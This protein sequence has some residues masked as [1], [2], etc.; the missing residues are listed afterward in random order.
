MKKD[1]LSKALVVLSVFAVLVTTGCG[2]AATTGNSASTK[3]TSAGTSAKTVDTC[4]TLE[5]FNKLLP[6]TWPGDYTEDED[7]TCDNE[8][9]NGC[10]ESVGVSM[11]SADQEN[12]IGLWLWAPDKNGQSGWNL[13][14]A[15]VKDAAEGDTVL[16]K[17][18]YQ[19]RPAY[20][21]A[22]IYGLFFAVEPYV[23]QVVWLG[24][25]QEEVDAVLAALKIY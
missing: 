22:D 23:V 13:L 11:L 8:D 4:M 12:V 25:A 17:T 21:Y 1:N 16:N 19:G 15:Y 3:T 2:S 20:E 10:C 24:S 14:E 9:E 6:T 5:D 7:R 18:T